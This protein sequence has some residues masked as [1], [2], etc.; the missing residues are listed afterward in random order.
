MHSADHRNKKIHTRV[1]SKSRKLNPCP[2][3]DDYCYKAWN[4]KLC[5]ECQP[6]AGTT[7][8]DEFP[9]RRGF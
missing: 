8:R 9:T 5:Q 1:C 3:D 7:F 6:T 4:H 2:E